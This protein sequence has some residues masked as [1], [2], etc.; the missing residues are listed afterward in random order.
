MNTD[1]PKTREEL[2]ALLRENG[3]KLTYSEQFFMSSFEIWEK[4]GASYQIRLSWPKNCDCDG[5]TTTEGE[6]DKAIRLMA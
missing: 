4:R 1:K 3:W 6:I 2:A 5:S